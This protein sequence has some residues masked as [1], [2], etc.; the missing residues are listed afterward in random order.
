MPPPIC[1]NLTWWVPV[2]GSDNT[3]T[4]VWTFK[5]AST[6]NLVKA[7]LLRL[8]SIL[9]HQS[10][11][12]PSIF[13]HPGS[14]NTMVEGVLH[15]FDLCYNSCLS[16]FV[17]KYQLQYPCSWI[18]YHLLK[19]V[20]SSVICAIHKQLFVGVT[21]QTPVPQHYINN[22]FPSAPILPL[23][24]NFRTMMSQPLR[25]FKCM[26]TGS[27]TNTTPDKIVSD[28][29]RLLRRGVLLPRFIS[30]KVTPTPA[31]PKAPP[32]RIST[33]N[34]LISYVANPTKILHPNVKR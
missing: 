5:E 30:Q 13:Y 22:W 14:R 31:S 18:L 26:T 11:M 15:R 33:S 3:P 27:V 1:T 32:P 16:F 25:S 6:I 7:N 24:T 23:T 10:T 19:E 34:S 9:N 28:Q 21:Y 2:L 29:T 17:C 20:I 12:S 4:V 8:Y